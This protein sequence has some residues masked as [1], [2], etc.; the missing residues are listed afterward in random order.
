MKLE[1]G[2]FG[3]SAI[4]TPHATPAQFPR[5]LEFSL[6]HSATA[7]GLGVPLSSSAI[8]ASLVSFEEH[9]L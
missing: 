5:D 7:F 4:K 8:G 2:R 3:S 6:R 9:P 1:V